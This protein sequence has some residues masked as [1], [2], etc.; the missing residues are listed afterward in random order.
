MNK[1]RLSTLDQPWDIIVIGGGITGAGILREAVRL[2]L[3]ALLVEQKDFA[4]GTSSRSSKL[5][6][7]G[8]R[9]LKEGK[10]GLTRASVL[11]REQLLEEG[12]GLIDPLGFLLAAYKGDKTGRLVFGAGLTIYDLM[13]LQWSH[14]YY[15]PRDFQMLAPHLT[16]SGLKGGFRYGDAQTDDARLVLRVI[17]EAVADGGT[18]VNYLAAQTILR[19]EA[20]QVDGLL[21][22]DQTTDQ[23]IEVHA[24]AI[25]NATGAWADKLRQQVGGEAKIRPLRGSHLV[26]PRW[27]LPAAQ[28]ISFLHPIDQRP[29]M[30]FPWEGVTL[31]GT[32]DVDHGQDLNR[33]PCISP[34]ETAYL[35]AA[36]ESQF[37]SLAITL[38]DV[39]AA[40]AGVRPVIGSG[41]DPSEESRDHV[42]WEEEGLLTVTGGKLTTFR[43]IALDALAAVAHLLPDMGK[44]EHD[45]P[46]LNPVEVA[47]ADD[48]ALDDAARR[49][50]LGR[51]AAAAPA[52]VE[53][54]QPG[55]L[56]PIPGTQTLWAELR[57]AARAESV[58]HLDD[59]LLRRV[60]LGLLLPEGG[61]AHLPRI[62]AI[63]QK[64]LGWDDGRW[65]E[66]QSAYLTL[67][68]NCYSIP[69]P[70]LI[71]DWKGML[72]EARAARLAEKE[73]ERKMGGKRPLLI[74]ALWGTAVFLGWWWW[75]RR[76]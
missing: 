62:R 11:E 72:A 57:W 25:I 9:Y 12:P 66:E 50:L 22:H 67:I 56:E 3:K 43:L 7:G 31:V 48:G 65:T 24:R 20:G 61:A 26:F 29:V 54:A 5:V 60:R 69:D 68:H 39:T 41:K 32:T 8:L 74:A 63:C 1:N 34:E 71:P 27:R 14:K 13:A 36:V 42:V 19:N 52:L 38:D 51:Y 35:L 10:L 40:F 73:G 15:S 21:L 4:W 37:P 28:A 2:G 70:A 17:Q 64:E 49:R 55:E 16:S 23:T 59:L 58:A 33:E 47:L 53:A 30:I 18:A 6:H 75:R 76:S 46:V 44:P 45:L